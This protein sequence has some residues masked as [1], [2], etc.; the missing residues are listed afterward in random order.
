M[1]VSSES[2]STAKVLARVIDVS[3]SSLSCHS[4]SFPG[5]GLLIEN[6]STPRQFTGSEKRSSKY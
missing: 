4:E 2:L 5:N 6:N 3:S 1:G